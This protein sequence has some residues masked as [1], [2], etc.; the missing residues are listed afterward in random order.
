MAQFS[1]DKTLNI[2]IIGCGLYTC[3]RGTDGFGTIMPAVF[4]WKRSVVDGKIYVCGSR[5]RSVKEAHNKITALSQYMRLN[6]EICFLPKSG[7]NPKAYFKAIRNIPRPACVIIAVPDHLH[8]EIAQFSIQNGLHT[9]VVKPLT[10]TLNEALKLVKLQKKYK[11]YCAVEFHKRLDYANM[12]LKDILANNKIGEPLYFIVEYSQ[13]L[14]IPIKHFR[15]WIR[16]T[17]VFQYLGVHYVDIIYYTTKALPIRVM[18]IGQNNYLKSLGID[19]Y[20]SITAIIE[21][22]YTKNKRFIS[23]IVTNW[24]DPECTSA[25]SD[26]KIKVIGTKGRFES[27]QKKRGI[28]IVSEDSGIEEPNPYFCKSYKDNNGYSFKGYGIESICQFLDDVCEIEKGEVKIEQLEDL[29]PT[30]KQAL[31][32]TAVIECVNKS[33]QN[34]NRWIDVDL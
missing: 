7:S 6:I 20:D 3:G 16:Y 8:S 17:N 18:A 22:G 27:D 34:H 19:T 32:S 21:W 33:L 29:R 9:L 2:A 1:K 13:R 5:S 15:N 30:F 4:E 28:M 31:I 12:M 23:T 25:M 14:S 10:S 26:Q 11:V 24:I